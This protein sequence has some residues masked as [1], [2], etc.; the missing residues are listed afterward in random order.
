MTP[1]ILCAMNVCKG[2]D[3]DLNKIQMFGDF[4]FVDVDIF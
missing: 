1:T 2:F 4:N 3:Y